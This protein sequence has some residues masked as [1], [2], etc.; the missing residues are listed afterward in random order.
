M[1]EI[2]RL[3]LESKEVG[4][5]RPILGIAGTAEKEV[6]ESR[7]AAGQNALVA[8]GLSMK[9]IE[10]GRSQV[11]EATEVLKSVDEEFGKARR[12]TEAILTAQ[13]ASFK[14]AEEASALIRNPNIDPLNLP[15]VVD[16][17]VMA[18]RNEAV[19]KGAR[20]SPQ[21]QAYI[22]DKLGGARSK[23]VGQARTAGFQREVQQ[24]KGQYVEAAHELTKRMYDPKTSQA[25]QEELFNDLM[26]LT[27]SMSFYMGEEAVEKLKVKSIQGLRSNQFTNL[28]MVNPKEAIVRADEILVGFT[29]IEKA[30]LIGQAQ[31]RLDRQHQE[32]RQK[33][34]D[35]IN[36]INDEN[37]AAFNRY[38]A[39]E[40]TMTQAA[41]LDIAKNEQR[42]NPDR[43]NALLNYEQRYRQNVRFQ[44][45]QAVP[46]P[47][48]PETLS[49]WETR[50]LSP[51]YKDKTFDEIIR[52]TQ[53]LG[54]SGE[55]AWPDVNRLQA[56][57]R[58]THKQELSLDQVNINRSRKTLERSMLGFFVQVERATGKANKFQIAEVQRLSNQFGRNME[59]RTQ[60]GETLDYD[61]EMRKFMESIASQFSPA[62]GDLTFKDVT[63]YESYEEALLDPAAAANKDFV[64]RMKFTDMMLE[65]GQ[66]NKGERA[67]VQ[68]ENKIKAGQ[69]ATQRLQ[70]EAAVRIGQERAQ[71]VVDR[72]RRD[73]EF[74]TRTKS[75]V[76]QRNELLKEFPTS[77]P[78][79]EGPQV[80][81]FKDGKAVPV[82][83]KEFETQQ[84]AEQKY[85]NETY[86]ALYFNAND[87]AEDVARKKK[88]IANHLKL[89]QSIPQQQIFRPGPP[90]PEPVS[91]QAQR[92]IAAREARIEE[93]KA[94]EEAEKLEEQ[95][96][97][98]QERVQALQKNLEELNKSLQEGQ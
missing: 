38:V 68:I 72:V 65:I 96:K 69:A 92:E 20:I 50:M 55:I 82:V 80:F 95:A 58:Q 18:I 35:R 34:Q 33:R 3:Q 66:Q 37:D 10:T 36:Q 60:A 32:Q 83:P 14:M 26:V 41:I 57:W 86:E 64:D 74:K 7:R 85:I 53:E 31:T 89:I 16:E 47:S 79:P 6:V 43:T 81:K 24:K 8:A 75:V 48:D 1:G 88:T 39:M 61:V 5:G 90:I 25:E 21:A 84:E 2:N 87:S 77:I 29:P 23:Q 13:D 28:F 9:A 40:E 19:T 51:E 22:I 73:A 44:K 54:E 30:Q 63:G 78:I 76:E 52:I 12:A 91:P 98:E 49:R 71:D 56:L 67:R 97:E 46:V 45:Q 62:L 42:A 17:A 15:Q 4:R 11:T 94:R 59:T 70:D 27:E 93:A